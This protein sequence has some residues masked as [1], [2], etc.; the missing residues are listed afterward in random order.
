MKIEEGL[1]RAVGRERGEREDDGRMNMT[2]V[3]RMQ[4]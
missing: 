2:K 4:V 3:Q 1:L